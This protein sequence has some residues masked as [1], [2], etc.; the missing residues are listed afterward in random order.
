MEKRREHRTDSSEV[1]LIF[2]RV[3]FE[4]NSALQGYFEMILILLQCRENPDK[5]WDVV[6]SVEAQIMIAFLRLFK[7]LKATYQPFRNYRLT[8]Q[9]PGWQTGKLEQ[10]YTQL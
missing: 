4:F 8:A 9:W 2:Q 7:V 1:E 3:V 6:P 5:G 10:C